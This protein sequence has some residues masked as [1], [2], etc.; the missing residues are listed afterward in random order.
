MMAGRGSS[1]DEALQLTEKIGAPERSRTPNLLIRS[2]RWVR[3][4]GRRITQ[5]AAVYLVFLG[6]F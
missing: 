4:N 1:V 2:K 5:L 3:A 6:A